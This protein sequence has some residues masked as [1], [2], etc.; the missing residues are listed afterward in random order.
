[1]KVL[2][3]DACAGAAGD[4]LLGALV[5][6]GLPEADLRACLARLPVTGYALEVRREKRLG[7]DVARAEVRMTRQEHHHRHLADIEGLIDGAGLP[8]RA[9][10]WAKAVFRRLA[11]AEAKVHGSTPEE[12]HFH[13]VGAVDSIVDIVGVCAGLAMLGV[14]RIVASPLPLGSGFVEMAHGRLPVPAPAVVELMRGVPT[15]ECDEPGELTTPTGAAILVTLAERFGPMPPMVIEAVGYGAGARQGPRTPNVVRVVL[16][17]S[18]DG[19]AA[20]GDTAW[21]LE[22]NIDDATG[23]TLGAATQALL[24]AGALDVWLTPVTMKKGRPGV[25]LACLAAD[26]ALEA[27]EAAVFRETTTFGV[28]RTRVQRTKLAREHVEVATPFGPVRVKVGRRA[29]ALVTASPEYE[30]CLRLAREHGMP[31]RQVYD[32]ARAAW[33]TGRSGATGAEGA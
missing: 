28:R 6:A 10:E 14:E 29:G 31:F 8:G 32:A 20:E 15:A 3:V 24:D 13:E 12:V 17:Q 19:A 27:V 2:Y 16:G 21:L 9:G 22:A 25:V 33:E 7:L 1:M 30:D 5:D 11:A 4:M 26:G 18:V 23:E